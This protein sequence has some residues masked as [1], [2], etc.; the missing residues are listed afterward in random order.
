MPTR[1]GE[2]RVACPSSSP[3]ASI[4]HP[5]RYPQFRCL[6]FA[7]SGPWSAPWWRTPGDSAR[8][9]TLEGHLFPIL[10]FLSPGSEG[11]KGGLH[12][13]TY[14]HSYGKNTNSRDAGKRGVLVSSRRSHTVRSG[15]SMKHK[16]GG[17]KVF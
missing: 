5:D 7:E 13:G 4:S 9:E 3:T 16:T 14:L 15:G 1:L 11:P 6:A 2:R 12:S 10:R 8:G 17:M